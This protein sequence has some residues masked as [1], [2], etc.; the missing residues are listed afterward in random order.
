M[1][2]ALLLRG[3]LEVATSGVG[4]SWRL[5]APQ[6]ASNWRVETMEQVLVLTENLSQAQPESASSGLG[7][8]S[9]GPSRSSQASNG[10]VTSWASAAQ[11]LSLVP[12]HDARPS[13]SGSSFPWH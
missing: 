12:W 3:D 5:A 7:A 10:T 4:R 9:C 2:T 8:F 11:A 6:L 1:G 13:L